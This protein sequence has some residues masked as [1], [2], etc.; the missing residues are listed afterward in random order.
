MK[1]YYIMEDSIKKLYSL[2]DQANPRLCR[3]A[4]KG[5]A[6]SILGVIFP[7]LAEETMD[8]LEK[9]TELFNHNKH[10]LTQ[11]LTCL[12]QDFHQDLD[13]EKIIDDFYAALPQLASCL[14]EDAVF[15]ADQDPAAFNFEEV[16]LCYP[17]FYAIGLYRVSHL[18]YG[19]GVRLLPRVLCEHAHSKTGIDIHPAA[20]IGH[21]FFIDHGT[22]VVIGKQLKL[23]TESK[24]FKV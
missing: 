7:E 19:M 10:L 11:I 12:S 24:F 2:Y 13:R 17:G 3:K 15:I 22:G 9:Y 14:K 21:P 18:L 4:I 20:K 16:I 5:F 1:G 23:E 8:T 6:E